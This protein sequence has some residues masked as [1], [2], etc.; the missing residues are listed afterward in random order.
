M[1]RVMLVLGGNLGDVVATIDGAVALI[2]N[3]IGRVTK[4]SSMAE[5][6]AWGFQK[7]TPMFINQAVEL[8]T[9][10]E[11]EEL[12]DRTQQIEREMG[13][14]REQEAET[15]LRNGERYASRVIDIDI[16]FYDEMLYN[17]E[18]L[19]LPHPLM[20]EREFML[21]PIVE[22]A[23]EWRNVALGGRSCEE[24]LKELK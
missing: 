13:R 6:E 2:D 4:R 8:E 14:E 16:I 9:D 21:R 1:G 19:T 18:R 3:R 15:K 23:P 7:E 11:P 20:G 5:S 24:L 10:L 22:I 12:L 17:S